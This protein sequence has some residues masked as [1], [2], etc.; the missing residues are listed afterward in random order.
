M[1]QRKK[2]IK[3]Y[4]ERSIINVGDKEQNTM[5]DMNTIA[6]KY[7][8]EVVFNNIKQTQTFTARPRPPPKKTI[9]DISKRNVGTTWVLVIILQ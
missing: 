2:T 1:S 8:E 3:L 7:V 5:N 4:E 9:G 6:K